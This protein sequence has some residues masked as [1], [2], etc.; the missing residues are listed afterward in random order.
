[1]IVTFGAY[2]DGATHCVEDVQQGEAHLVEAG[3]PFL[4]LYVASMVLSLNA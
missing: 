4:H 3:T 1:M 2:V